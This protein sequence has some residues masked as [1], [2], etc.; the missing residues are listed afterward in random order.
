M[1]QTAIEY[2]ESFDNSTELAIAHFTRWNNEFNVLEKIEDTVNIFENAVSNNPFIY[3]TSPIIFDTLGVSSVREANINGYRLLYE[4][5]EQ[6]AKKV[7]IASIIL[8]QRQSVIEQLTK[9]CLMYR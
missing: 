4:V 7:V 6:A 5:D 8:G 3:P 1:V 2:T 9:H